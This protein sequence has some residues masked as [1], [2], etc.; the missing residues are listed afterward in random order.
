M[1]RSR[2]ALLAA[3]PMLLGTVALGP[4]S[5]ATSVSAANSIGFEVPSVV[6]PIHTFGEPDIAIDK[7]G[8]VFASGP[9]GTGTQRSM[10]LGSVDGGHTYRVVSPGPPPTALAGTVDAPGGGDTDINFDRSGKQYF[11]D[12]YALTCLRTAT[13][14]NGGANVSQEIYP[15]GCRGVPGADRQ[16]LAVYD[17]APG[18]P[19]SSAYS[20][21]KPLI[22]LEYNDVVNGAHW[23]KSNASTDPAPGGPGLTYNEATNGSNSPCV[24]TNGTTNYA[25]FGADGYPAIDQVTG[26]VFQAAFGPTDPGT[27]K[28][29]MLLNIG[30]PDAAGNLTF[31]DAPSTAKP[32]GDPS[33]LITIATGVPADAGDA[34]NFVVASMDS[35]RNLFVAWVGKSLDPTLRQAYVSAAGA[36][37]GSASWTTKL[38]S[39][40]PSMVSIFPWVKA[41][42]PGRADVVWYGSDRAVSPNAHGGQKWDVFMAQAVYPT[43]STGVVTGAAPISTQVQ[44]TPHPMHYDEVCLAGTACIA[45]QGNRNL[46]DFFAVTIDKSGAAEVVYDDTSN[47][48]IQSPIP[49]TLPQLVDHSGAPLVTVARQSSG[50]GLFGKPVSGAN[51][52]PV[53]GMSDPAGDALYPVIGGANQR[54]MDI[55]RSQL[56]LSGDGQTLTV[57]MQ[58]VDLSNPALTAAAIPGTTNLQYVTRWQMGNTVYYAAMENAASNQPSFYAGAAK[59][60]DLCSVSACFPHVLTYPE[61]GPG[62]SY[63]GSAESGTVQCPASPS[64]SDPCSLT[65]KV[66]TAHIGGPTANSLLE[67]VG[68]Y[69]L[70]AATPEGAQDNGT[71]QADAVPL[72]VDGVCCYNFMASVANGGRGPCHEADGDGQM[73]GARSGEAS[74]HF[75]EDSC[76]DQHAESVDV[77]D[78]GDGSEFHSDRTS[79][80]MY[81]DG[82]RTITI[83]G[84]GT[85]SGRRVT[86]TAIGT[87]NGSLAPGVFSLS[88]SDGYSISG[89]LLSGG[90]VLR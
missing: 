6:D 88:L 80:V 27:G 53:S 68:G 46:A 5:R 37:S 30:T 45:Q 50:M 86:F 83:L 66:R 73:R 59:S 35:A 70:A 62:P 55:R 14:N 13:T 54:G 28:A 67:E 81:D 17:P 90:I 29:S 71:A 33:R 87:D 77:K 20:G 16:S 24:T 10:W 25:P 22:Y 82:A 52:S 61:P 60:I 34:A 44:V 74:V 57:T 84:T 58:V 39:A 1:A 38:V 41:G 43:S 4:M 19:N 2:F 36:G 89:S 69:A 64:A 49:P 51:N 18:T 8:R 42:G 26:K 56:Q 65:I 32:C 76:E 3:L 15:A 79:A 78:S 7:L 12:L 9:T 23:V 31:L 11:T 75:D 63:G 85:H 48:L 47:G 21:P 72:E 40:P